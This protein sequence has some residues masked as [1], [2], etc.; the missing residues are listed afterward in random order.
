MRHAYFLDR[1]MPKARAG[2]GCAEQAST[3]GTCPAQSSTDSQAR[4]GRIT[5]CGCA[6]WS[7]GGNGSQLVCA[8]AG[9]CQPGVDPLGG[10]SPHGCTSC[11]AGIC[12]VSWYLR[13]SQQIL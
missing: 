9:R 7:E 11:E 12:Q 4:I 1:E 13:L 2:A 6:P 5:C 3:P 8:A 10:S